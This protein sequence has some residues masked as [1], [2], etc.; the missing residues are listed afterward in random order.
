MP[1]DAL[2]IELLGFA[3]ALCTTAAFLPQA[4]RV[5]RTRSADD[6]SIP[7]FVLLVTGLS[8]WLAYGILLVSWPIIVANVFSLAFNLFILTAALRFRRP[9]APPSTS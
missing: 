2:L 8:L 7:M 9:A 1:T 4:I 5:W 6:L 3:A